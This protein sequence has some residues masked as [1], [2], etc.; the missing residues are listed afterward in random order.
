MR[1]LLKLRAKNI[2][3]KAFVLGLKGQWHQKMIDKNLWKASAYANRARLYK[4]T[5]KVMKRQQFLGSTQGRVNHRHAEIM[6]KHYLKVWLK[7]YMVGDIAIRYN[8][9]RLNKL[10]I[11]LF[12]EL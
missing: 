8:T 1:S 2:M 4:K 12:Y 5:F 9:R 10:Q 11:T 3:R 6:K 7:R